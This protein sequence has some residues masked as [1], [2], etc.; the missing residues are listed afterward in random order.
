MLEDYWITE[1]VAQ[2]E[3]EM[4]YDYMR[5]FEYVMK[6]DLFTDRRY[7][8]GVSEYGSCGHIPLLKSDFNSAY[9]MS[10]MC[11]LWNRKLLLDFLLPGESPWDIEI[12]GTT[13]LA[14]K[15]DSVLVLG[16]ESWTEEPTTCPVRHTLAHRSGNPDEYMLDELSEADRNELEK[17]GYV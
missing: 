6:M 13:R 12:I 11:G 7:A 16:T 4:L 3:V 9:H 8:G 15:K 10:L 17:L 14:Q 2:R 1:H 5:Q